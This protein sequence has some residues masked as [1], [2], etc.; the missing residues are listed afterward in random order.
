MTDIATD[1][2]VE[3][4]EHLFPKEK[5]FAKCSVAIATVKERLKKN[6]RRKT[7]RCAYG[8]NQTERQNKFYTCIAGKH[9]SQVTAIRQAAKELQLRDRTTFTFGECM[10]PSH[11]RWVRILVMWSFYSFLFFF[12]LFFFS[13]FFSL[14]D[15]AEIRQMDDLA[16]ENARQLTR[17][18][19]R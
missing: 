10:F 9:G 1:T 18:K 19:R 3:H 13:L 11:S 7:S 5:R 14:A 6:I 8:R 12:P 4:Q 16:W 15:A 2:H 17:V